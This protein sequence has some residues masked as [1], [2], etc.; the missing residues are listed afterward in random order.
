[1]KTKLRLAV[2]FGNRG[3][4]PGEVIA[5][6]R[7]EMSEAIVKAGFTPLLMD[8][9]LTRYGAIESTQES[10]K[11]ASFLEEE[12]PDGVV[13][14]LPNFGD[15]TAAALACRDAGVPILVQAYPDVAGSMDF[16][17]RRDAFCGKLSLMDVFLQYKIPFSVNTPHVIHPLDE[18]FIQ[19]LKDFGGVCRVVNGMRRCTVIALGA[20]TSA[21]KTVRYDEIALQ[22]YG[23]TVE[24]VDLSEVFGKANAISSD[25][26]EVKDQLKSLHDFADCTE[27][28]NESLIKMA[29]L[30]IVIEEYIKELEADMVAIRC[31]NELEVYYGCAPCAI[32]GILGDVGVPV[33]C[34]VDVTN[35]VMMYALN[36]AT[37]SSSTILD[38]N[39]NAGDDPDSCILFH[40]GPVP[41]SMVTKKGKMVEHPMFAKSYG[42][43][44]GWG[45]VVTRLKPG[46]F[47]FASSKTEDGKFVT[48]FGNGVV[49]PD[50][51][52]SKFFGTCGVVTIENLQEKLLAIGKNGFRHH[53]A[54]SYGK[55]AHILKEAFTT[56]LGYDVVDL[57]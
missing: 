11:F 27:A 24:T 50:E 5:E 23:I 32:A 25:A 42:P 54:I 19:Q 45:P 57:P 12:K 40:C 1:M 43:G 48:Y 3:F 4:F 37:D 15:E 49:L 36:L 38:W 7:K 2:F 46:E 8:E 55:I 47:S 17:H 28:P 53:V 21:F 39:N 20:R 44:C 31:W 30:K 22:K 41:N 9:S 10:K 52:E 56:Y 51:I 13:I 35:A 14:C 34:E 6:A 29:K 16:A 18:K 33:A 26:A